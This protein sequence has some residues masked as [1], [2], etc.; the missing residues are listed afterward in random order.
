M[1][2]KVDGCNRVVRSL[3]L[4]S[5]HRSRLLRD[6]DVQAHIPLRTS[7]YRG[8]MCAV[9]G[10]GRAAR[11]RGYCDPHAK[12]VKKYGHPGPAEIATRRPARFNGECLT[13]VDACHLLG[14]G[15]SVELTAARLD[16]TAEGLLHHL[17]HHGRRDVAERVA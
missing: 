13:C 2:C 15:E 6:G 14:L 3:G 16:L 9:E 7:T 1:T 11:S 12:R 17:R 8:E 5:G 4:C 10:C